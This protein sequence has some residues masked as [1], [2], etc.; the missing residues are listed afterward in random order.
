MQ[1]KALIIASKGAM[2]APV[3]QEKHQAALGGVARGE[4]M[5]LRVAVYRH[6]KKRW[7]TNVRDRNSAGNTFFHHF[8]CAKLCQLNFCLYYHFQW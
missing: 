3:D 2:E 7:I 5:A 8:L 1:K 4:M 6:M